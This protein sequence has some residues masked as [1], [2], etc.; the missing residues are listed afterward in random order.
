MD[1]PAAG[2]KAVNLTWDVLGP[3]L[4]KQFYIAKGRMPLAVLRG[5]ELEDFSVELEPY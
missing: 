4:R 3:P 1:Y 5:R 2:A